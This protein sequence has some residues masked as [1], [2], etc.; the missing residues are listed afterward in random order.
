MP[1]EIIFNVE[2]DPEGGYTAV[3]L[4]YPIFTQGNSMDELR[5][6][7]RDAVL[8]YFDGGDHPAVIRLHL[9]LDELIAV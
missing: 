9:V 6:M 3:A 7:V 1:S 5:A 8:C 2:E 4:G